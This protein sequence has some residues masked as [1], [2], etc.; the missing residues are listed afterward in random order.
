MEASASVRAEWG[1]RVRAEYGSAAVTQELT[2][3]LIQTGASPDLIRTGQRIAAEELEHSFLSH[4]VF[5]AAGGAELPSIERQSLSLSRHAGW[6]LDEEIL[7]VALRFFCLNEVV[8]VPLFAHFRS[9]CTVPV[10]RAALDK[11]LEDEAGHGRFG[12]D[13]LDWMLD[14]RDEDEVRKQV[15]ALLPEMF[16]DL[17]RNYGHFAPVGSGGSG[18]SGDADDDEARSRDRAWGVVPASEYGGILE[19]TALRRFHIYFDEREIDIEAAWKSSGSAS[20]SE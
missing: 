6:S 15:A 17:R 9:G 5:V 14:Q 16:G 11:I 18:G 8:A 4:E 13:M 10:A 19:G 7:A 12:F 1:N 2:L 20:A 3:W